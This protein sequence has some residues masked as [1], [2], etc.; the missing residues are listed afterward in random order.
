M[1]A[2]K[3]AGSAYPASLTYATPPVESWAGHAARSI[4][5]WGRCGAVISILG[6][7]DAANAGQLTDHVQRCASYCEWLIIDLSDLDF[8]GTAGFSA[9]TAIAQRCAETGVHCTTVPGAAAARLLHICDPA[10][11]NLPT[12]PSVADALAGAHAFQQSRS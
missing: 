10:A 12:T 7:L 1:P 5:R 2:L 11:E 9:L 6:E 4:T 3:T 8:L